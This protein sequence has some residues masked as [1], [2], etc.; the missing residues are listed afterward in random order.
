MKH[1]RICLTA[2]FKGDSEK[3][4]VETMLKSFMP[5]CDGLVVALTGLKEEK[6]QLKALIKK[7]GG[8]YIETNP[9]THPQIY[10]KDKD[11]YFFASFCEARNV[12]FKMADEG[13]YDWYTWA[14]CDDILVNGDELNKVA[15][16]ALGKNIDQVFFTYWYSIL[17]DKEGNFSEKNV[18]IEHL[19]E[20]L[21]VPKKTKWVSRLHEV[22][23]MLDGNYKPNITMYE[24]D[25]KKKQ[26]C[27]WAHITSKERAVDAL[28]RN[29][30]ILEMQIKEENS[31]DPRTIFYLAKTYY[32]L[33]QK[34][35]DDLALF[36][37]DDY[38]D[39]SGWA[40]EVS[41]SWEYTG[42]IWARRGDHRRAIEAYHKAIEVFP[43]RHMP[44]LYLAREYSELQQFDISNHWLE[45]ALRMD[46][47]QAR[48]VI[49]NP[50]EFMFMAAS[51]R[52][53]EAIR[54]Q[55]IGDAIKWLKVRNEIAGLTD[56]GMIKTLEES[57][58]MNE[59]AKHVVQ[60]AAWLKKTNHIN[61]VKHL[62]QALPQELGREAF[63]FQMANSLAEPKKWGPKSI[64]YYASWG[65]EH[66]EGWSPKSL[67][68]GIGGSERAVI[69]LAS[70]FA[71]RGY[72][73]TV[74]GDPRDDEGVYE[75]VTYRPWYE[76]NWNDEFNTLILWRSPHLLDLP[77][78]A[79]KLYMDMHD[80]CSQLDFTEERMKKLDKVFFKS[81]Y[82]RSM[83]PKLPESKAVI[84]SNGL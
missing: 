39:K 75:G 7:Y 57:L 30:K 45:L 59:A 12:T 3:E 6:K 71:K 78:K 37:L 81:K 9:D 36:M 26:M 73:V 27:A 70:R 14:D 56:D 4:K 43:M 41:N 33:R 19:R 38:R 83:L 58:E 77:L 51:L 47:P 84:I 68:K 25:T 11:G 28:I 49:G 52:Y 21:I 8:R 10:G 63:A 53:N 62:L 5:H 16:M 66:F 18:E 67:K 22:N 29:M 60:Y 40:E 65:A 74:Y 46:P 23:V 1:A 54:T 42:N 24:F 34:D 61:K 50:V 48:T 55:K 2:I 31:K 69:E 17:F 64:V 32:D 20:R 15:D 13:Q 79:K 82:H 44:Y 72:E 35:K 80:I 76:I